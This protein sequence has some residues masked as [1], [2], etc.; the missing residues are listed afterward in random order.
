MPSEALAG[1]LSPRPDVTQLLIEANRG[2][3]VAHERLW[4]TVYGE[5]RSIAR[6]Q[7]GRFSDQTISTTEVVHEAYLRLVRGDEPD[8]ESRLHFFALC[9]TIM[10]RLLI[11]R[12]R[13]RSRLRRGGGHDRADVPLGL[14]P[15]DAGSHSIDT[16]LSLDE[17]LGALAH[18]APRLARIV[19]LHFFGGLQ[20]DEI[21][22]LL[23]VSRRT[24]QRDWRKARALLNQRLRA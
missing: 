20:N 15:A 2:D 23:G 3:A 18:A 7:L 19:E 14:L 12:A 21:A 24:V 5:L 4:Q 9:A 10:R 17:A 8:Y 1:G 22:D 11:D 13:A 6:R 16:L